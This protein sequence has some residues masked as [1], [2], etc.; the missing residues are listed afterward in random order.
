[1]M[2]IANT[3]L[4]SGMFVL[5]GQA[6]AQETVAGY[7][8]GVEREVSAGSYSERTYNRLSDAYEQI[9]EE[10]YAEAYDALE[11]LLERNERDDFTAATI[12]QAM[13]FIHA[14]QER[15]REAINM[16]QRAIDRNALPNNQHYEMIL[17]VAQLYYSIERYQDALDQLDI[18]FCVTPDE[19][20][21]KVQVWVMK[22]SIHA[23]I[24]EFR[25][26]IQAIDRAIALS[27][28]PK[29]NWYQL[30]LGMHF[31]LEEFN[32]AADVLQILLRMNPEKKDYWI[33]LASVYS[34]LDRTRD[35]MAVL[36]LA[37][38][39]GLLER[40]SEYLQLASLQQEFDFP[41]KA[42]ELLQEGLEQ[43]IIENTRR[44]WEMT[45]GAWYAARELE[46]A[47]EAYERAGAQSTDGEID[48]QRAF[49]LTDQERWDEA[50]EALSRALELGGL[51]D[52]QTGNAWLLLGTAR[53]NLGNVDGAM[54]AFNEARDYGRVEDAARE[55]MNHIRNESS[56]QAS[57]R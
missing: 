28:E 29:E 55:W 7:Q 16:F 22:A 37:H 43:G 47:L 48:L 31:E 53:Y 20:K 49:I 14:Q 50:V 39:E 19:Q 42:A 26:A 5:S 36:S 21:N 54:D 38:R 9:G 45:G 57:S 11:S 10:N 4:L 40:Q 24:E 33:Q 52:S 15:Y 51:S 32:E 3:I 41:R 25:N 23:Q 27:D 2:K 13:A 17:Q 56:R 12:M 6:L 18:W 1:M 46:R 8:C 34:Q 30:K 44:N 35:S